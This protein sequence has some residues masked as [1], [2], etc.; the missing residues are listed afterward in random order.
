MKLEQF[1]ATVWTPNMWCE[2]KED[3]VK[4]IEPVSSGDLWLVNLIKQEFQLKHDESARK[5]IIET[6]KRLEKKI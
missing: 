3:K 1:N 6:G 5:W 2:I 4:E